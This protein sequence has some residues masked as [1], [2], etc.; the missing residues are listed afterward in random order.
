MRL[1]CV[2]A[3]SVAALITLPTAIYIYIYIYMY[4]CMYVCI[5]RVA[6]GGGLGHVT[7]GVEPVR[8]HPRLGRLERKRERERE[9]EGER[10]RER[11][12]GREGEREGRK[13]AARD[14]PLL[15]RLG[16]MHDIHKE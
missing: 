15:G 16:S 9:G 5:Y 14:H 2:L 3:P 8:D 11:E 10:E 1:A 4:V 6:L 12:G 7:H 13:R